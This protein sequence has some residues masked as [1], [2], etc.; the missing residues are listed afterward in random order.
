[1][2]NQR[3]KGK[4]TV[5]E[6]LKD[7]FKGITDYKGY[8]TV[9]GYWK[10]MLVL[11]PLIII[12]TLLLTYFG[13]T[14]LLRLQL[15]ALYAVWAISI[16]LSIFVMIIGI[17]LWARRLRDIGFNTSGILLFC[18]IQLALNYIFD[19]AGLSIVSFIFNIFTIYVSTLKSDYLLNKDWAIKNLKSFL[20]IE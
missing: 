5:S 17:P 20:R 2:Q 10:V 12:A 15:G 8:T 18:A 19:K 13:F 1:M 7:A 14:S 9:A 16:V 11:I 4:L 3:E 6:A